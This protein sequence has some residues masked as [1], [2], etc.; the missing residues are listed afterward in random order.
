MNASQSS[1]TAQAPA[2]GQPLAALM[3]RWQMLASAWTVAG[4][5]EFGDALDTLLDTVDDERAARAGDLAA[6]L[7]VFADGAL[8]PSRPQLARLDELA[9]ALFGGSAAAGN[10]VALPAQHARALEARSTVC[11]LGVGD[12]DGVA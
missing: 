6:Y 10:V 1:S 2:T 12:G 3:T 4:A 11:L 5:R 8:L 9:A 7:A